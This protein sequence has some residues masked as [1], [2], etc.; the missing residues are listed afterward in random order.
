MF[1]FFYCL[2]LRLVSCLKWGQNSL[3]NWSLS[4]KTNPLH[5]QLCKYSQLE[6]H[7]SNQLKMEEEFKFLAI[8]LYMV[9]HWQE[10][11]TKSFKKIAK[12][13]L[14][15]IYGHWLIIAWKVA[16]IIEKK[17]EKIEKYTKNCWYWY[18]WRESNGHQSIS[19]P[20]LER[21]LQI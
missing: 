4:L 11:L 9:N 5:L 3:N 13:S 19:R 10:K 15:S 14:I 20:A 6:F 1:Y 17:I 18:L 16:K 21:Q 8:H 12:S 2:L 7:G